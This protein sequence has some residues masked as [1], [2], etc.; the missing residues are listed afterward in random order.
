M[1][2]RSLVIANFGG[3][4]SLKEVEPFLIALFT[5]PEVFRV[6]CLFRPFFALLAKKRSKRVIEDYETIGGKS[7]IYEDTEYVAERLR[8][9][10]LCEV[11]SFHRYL[12][13]THAA[14][15]KQMEASPSRRFLI[16][17]L[18]P[19]FTYATTGSIATYFKKRLS[20]QRQRSLRWIKSYPTH[21][22]FISLIQ[23]MIR[24]YLAEHRLQEEET[25]LLF[26][27]HGLPQSF[28]DEG[29]PY[30]EECAAS[31]KAVAQAFPQALSR[32]SYQSK[33]GRAVWI[34]PATDTLC[35]TLPQWK[36]DQRHLLFIPISF[37]SDHVETLFEIERAYMPIV[38]EKGLSAHRLPAPNRRVD[39]IEAIVQIIE[40][41]PTVNNAMLLR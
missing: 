23:K 21:T 29:D 39:W 14:F 17:P 25:I 38:R 13:A 1:N 32:L 5:D 11:L 15:F 28:I 34:A 36:G 9:R 3:P 4:R 40:G 12:P 6:S 31:F 10:L 19:Q 8:E 18:F 41:E 33:V 24:E 27:A 35:H 7:P 37:T 22:A 2:K 16:F 20:K 26:S 30:Q